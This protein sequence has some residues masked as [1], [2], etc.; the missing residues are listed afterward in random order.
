MPSATLSSH[1][2][3][4]ANARLVSA[5]QRAVHLLRAN[6]DRMNDLIGFLTENL[7]G[8][9]M[10]VE[11]APKATGAKCGAPE[12]DR[13][14]GLDRRRLAAATLFLCT[15]TSARIMAEALMRQAAGM[16]FDARPAGSHPAS[17]RT[18][19]RSRRSAAR[20]SDDR[21]RSGA[22]MSSRARRTRDGLR[23]YRATTQRARIARCV[24]H[25]PPRTG[26]W[27]IRRRTVAPSGRASSYASRAS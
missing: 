24:W 15:H 1:L 19:S 2:K 10:P 17:R 21:L 14:R 26:A 5:R 22:G 7:S 18:R 27:R 9:G 3:E 8:R 20:H 11:C 16:S 23:L 6:F 12:R 25:P 4:L 13:A